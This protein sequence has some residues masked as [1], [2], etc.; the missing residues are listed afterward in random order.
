MIFPDN[1]EVLGAAITGVLETP[2]GLFPIELPLSRAFNER[3]P[4]MPG[5]ST[6]VYMPGVLRCQVCVCVC[7]EGRGGEGVMSGADIYDDLMPPE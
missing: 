3:F 6:A 7:V 5:G 1:T 2:T 4:A